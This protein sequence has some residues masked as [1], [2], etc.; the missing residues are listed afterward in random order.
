[1]LNASILSNYSVTNT[2]IYIIVKSNSL[3]QTLHDE[4]VPYSFK[5]RYKILQKVHLSPDGEMHVN[6][7]TFLQDSC[8]L[9][10]H[11]L[12]F[13]FRKDILILNTTSS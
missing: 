11:I 10:M 5:H 9:S 1:M 7:K 13:E 12:H 6:C 4:L 2:T 8:T 3:E